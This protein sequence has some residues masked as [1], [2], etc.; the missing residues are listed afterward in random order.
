M[1]KPAAEY[2]WRNEEFGFV[3]LVTPSST[4]ASHVCGVDWAVGRVSYA[5]RIK[6][7]DRPLFLAEQPTARP[8][9]H[10]PHFTVAAGHL[11]INSKI[12]RIPYGR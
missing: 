11:N 9:R 1:Y 5:L 2:L 6:E 4:A 12:P 10:G 8:T 3:A 7:G